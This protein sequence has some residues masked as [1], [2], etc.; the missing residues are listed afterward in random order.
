MPNNVPVRGSESSGG[1]GKNRMIPTEQVS[2][3]LR[4]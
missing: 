1:N 2:K 3:F 4:D